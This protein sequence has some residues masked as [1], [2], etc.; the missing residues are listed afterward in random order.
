VVTGPICGSIPF[1][2]RSWACC[3]RSEDLLA[4]EV[5][6][7]PVSKTTVMTE[8]PILRGSGLHKPRQTSHG[9]FNGEV[10]IAP[11]RWG[12][13]LLPGENLHL[14]VG[15]VRLSTGSFFIASQPG[16]DQND[17]RYQDQETLFE[18]KLQYLI[19][20]VKDLVSERNNVRHGV[21]RT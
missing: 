11:P 13:S 8:R 17:G 14:Y 4:G 3:N 15:H 12:P 19:Y 1:G 6:V 16:A 18:S 21:A 20:H 5:G 7:N 10:I 2:R 9:C